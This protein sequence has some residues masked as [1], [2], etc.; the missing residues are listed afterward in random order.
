MTANERQHDRRDRLILYT[1]TPLGAAL[2]L[3]TWFGSAL[4]VTILPLDQHH[5]L[6]QIVGFGLIFWGL[7]HWR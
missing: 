1:T 6:G 2:L 4:G 3:L 7:T 5:I